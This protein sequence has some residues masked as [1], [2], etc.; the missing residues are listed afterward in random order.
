METPIASAIHLLDVSRP[1]HGE[2]LEDVVSTVGVVNG[3][4]TVSIF[5]DVFV[6]NT[7]ILIP[8]LW[9]PGGELN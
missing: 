3:Q 2:T 8:I 9:D 4:D 1:A 5:Y 6:I 7:H